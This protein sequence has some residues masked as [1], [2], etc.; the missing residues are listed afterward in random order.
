MMADDGMSPDAQREAASVPLAGSASATPPVVAEPFPA[1]DAAA[2]ATC[3]DRE[4]HVV[5]RGAVPPAVVA[6]FAAR[7]PGERARLSASDFARLYP[8]RSLTDILPAPIAY[9]MVQAILGG[10]YILQDAWLGC[11]PPPPTPPHRDALAIWLPLDD[12]GSGTGTGHALSLAPGDMV[13]VRGARSGKP[14]DGAAAGFLFEPRAWPLTALRSEVLSAIETALRGRSPEGVVLPSERL[15]GGAEISMALARLVRDFRPVD[16]L[17]LLRGA[18]EDRGGLPAGT[19]RWAMPE[20]DP[21]PPEP[22]ALP[23]PGT[24]FG[25]VLSVC[26]QAGSL[27]RAL[28]GLASQERPFDQILLVDD[29]SRD[30]S[31]QILMDFAADRPGVA[32]L[33]NDGRLGEIASIAKAVEQLRTGYVTWAAAEDLLLPEAAARLAAAFAAQPAAAMAMGETAVAMVEIERRGPAERMDHGGSNLGNLPP[34][35]APREVPERL[36]CRRL[37]FGTAWAMRRDAVLEAGGFDARLGPFADFFTGL[38]LLSRHGLAM[39]PARLSVMSVYDADYTRTAGT[40]PEVVSACRDRFLARLKRPE[41]RD[42]YWTFAATPALVAGM[43]A[44]SEVYT[45][46][47]AWRPQHWDLML[48]GLAW[49]LRHG[50]LPLARDG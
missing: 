18:L 30:D 24:E 20:Y 3:I 38:V 2:I 48:R 26:N 23:P 50:E 29:G 27:R 39:V 42:V 16:I 43:P 12:A 9:Q 15:A 45:T 1:I 6:S 46:Y 49:S 7:L 44:Q 22:A 8:G 17:P 31:R 34:Y 10:A 47:F 37:S 40:D 5:V 14:P 11:G 21:A 36:C 25:L 33:S 13:L 4:G 32:V 35:L 19:P 41:F 28:E